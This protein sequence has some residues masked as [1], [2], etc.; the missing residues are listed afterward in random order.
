MGRALA[1]LVMLSVRRTVK[2]AKRLL[3]LD[4]EHESCFVDLNR[5]GTDALGNGVPVPGGDRQAA[6]PDAWRN[7]PGCA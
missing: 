7:E 4:V 2:V 5:S 1:P 6:L 3:M